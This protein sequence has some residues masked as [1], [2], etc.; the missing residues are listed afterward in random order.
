MIARQQLLYLYRSGRLLL[1]LSTLLV[2]LGGSLLSSLIHQRSLNRE[3]VQASQKERERWLHQGTKNPHLAAH[4]GL[5]AFR[6]RS[7]GSAI[8]PGVGAFTGSSVWIEAHKENTPQFRESDQGADL[9]S[10]GE[11]TP[12]YVLTVLFPLVI[13]LLTHDALAGERESGTLRTLLSLGVRPRQILWGK[14]WGTLAALL[15]LGLPVLLLGSFT[16]AWASQMEVSG[17]S[18]VQ[19]SE[20]LL[21]YGIYAAVFALLG[22]YVSLRCPQPRTALA[23][24]SG[25]WIVLCL[26]GSRIAS[27]AVAAVYP[28]PT[29]ASFYARLDSALERGLDGTSTPLERRSAVQRKLAPGQALQGF[30]LQAEEEHGYVV[31]DTL[32]GE[33]EE[34]YR[35]QNQLNQALGL[36]CPSLAVSTLSTHLAGTDWEHSRDFER[37]AEEYRRAMVKTMNASLQKHASEANYVGDDHLW[38]SLPPFRYE[39]GPDKS[40]WLPW[41][42]LL[43]WIGGPVV[44]LSRSREL[45]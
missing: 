7:L 1:A 15:S 30:A 19:L 44:L 5:Y 8:D 13:L 6:P 28:A 31:Y 35:R 38:E 29:A 3:I 33:L 4:W 12:A 41:V 16:I 10:L 11:L 39:P 36:L 25:I 45:L 20:M 17:A 9:A 37:K 22:L 2:L 26:M 34:T 21:A 27:G 14:C 40:V 23:V 32:Y 43:L 18:L 24:C 42:A